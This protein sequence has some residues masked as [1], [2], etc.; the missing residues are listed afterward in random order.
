MTVIHDVPNKTCVTCPSYLVCLS[1]KD[2]SGDEGI[3]DE[4]YL[5]QCVACER[6]I[7]FYP[8]EKDTM[9]LVPGS[10]AK[11]FPV[12]FVHRE[13]GYVLESCSLE[14]E[15][16]FLAG[17]AKDWGKKGNNFYCK[18]CRGSGKVKR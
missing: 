18:K 17:T 1:T 13:G 4:R 10:P 14:V 2:T 7:F 3:I 9:Q 5:K 12:Y 8:E 6:Y 15:I 16:G 11:P